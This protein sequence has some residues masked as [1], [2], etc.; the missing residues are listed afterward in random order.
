MIWVFKTSVQNKTQ[1]RQVTHLLNKLV[2]TRGKWNFDLDDCDRILRIEYE[3][4]PVAELMSAMR[5][6]GFICEELA[7]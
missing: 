5:T 7:G 1:A 6:A 3:D 2:T 4:L